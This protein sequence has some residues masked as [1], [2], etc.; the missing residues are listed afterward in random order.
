MHNLWCYPYSGREY[1]YSYTSARIRR[2]IYDSSWI[3]APVSLSD[4]PPLP[5]ENAPS[6]PSSS[7]QHQTSDSV[8]KDALTLCRASDAAKENIQFHSSG[9]FHQFPVIMTILPFASCSTLYSIS[10]QI[11]DCTDYYSLCSQ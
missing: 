7:A 2:T 4:L 5:D 8:E 9:I 6:L 10:I 3:P 1:L 11:F